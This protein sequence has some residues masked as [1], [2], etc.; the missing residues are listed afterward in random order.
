MTSAAAAIRRHL[1]TMIGLVLALDV[2][3]VGIYYTAGV[4]DASADVRRYYT[5]GWMIV[6]LIIVLR[7]LRSIR[8]E[9]DVARRARQQGSR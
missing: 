6:T 3:A 8:A 7:G 2:V 5:F 4:Q 9:R 1:F